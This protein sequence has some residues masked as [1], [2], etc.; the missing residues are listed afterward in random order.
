MDIQEVAALLHIH[1]ESVAHG[2][3][4]SHIRDL[5][6]HALHQANAQAKG[7]MDKIREE[8]KAKKAEAVEEAKPEPDEVKPVSNEPREEQPP[9]EPIADPITDSKIETQPQTTLVDRRL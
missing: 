9:V 6:L 1:K 2:T 7:E 8:E 4:M 3:P 5:A